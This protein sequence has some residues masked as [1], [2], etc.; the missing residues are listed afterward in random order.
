MTR[1]RQAA[2]RFVAEMPDD[3]KTK[4]SPLYSPLLSIEPVTKDNAIKADEA[5]IFTSSNG[6]ANA[7]RGAGR[8]AYC[9]GK[10]TTERAKERGWSAQMVG[11]TANELATQ[12]AAART[13]H[14]LV[15]IRGRHT[16]G[17]VVSRLQ[18][19]GKQARDCIVY[20]QLLHTLSDAARTALLQEKLIIVPLFSPRTAAQ[21]A[22]KAPRTTSIH[23]VALSDAVAEAAKPVQSDSVA[24]R[25]DATTM[26][27]A[28]R[29]AL[30]AG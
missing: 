29:V 18:L 22:S 15:H 11:Q 24:V 14:A 30:G 27:E 8:V 20:D 6:V 9:V 2:E 19:A 23:V 7:P 16:R 1:P 28:I 4:L 10:A 5:A 17:D 26:Y 3:L 21:F 25:P 12:L 13:G